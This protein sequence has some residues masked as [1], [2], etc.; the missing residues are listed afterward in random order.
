M[1]IR[2]MQLKVTGISPLL[3]NNPQTADPLNKYAKQKKTFTSKRDKTDNDYFNIQLIEMQSKIYW[4]EELGMYIPSTWIMG[5]LAGSSHK[6][7]RISKK[8][9]RGGVFTTDSKLKLNYK[10]SNKVKTPDDII[11][12][13]SF[14]QIMLL[15]QEGVRIPKAV[16]IF[17]DWSFETEIE[18]DDSVV[19][20]AN[21]ADI[22][23]HASVYGGYG[24]FRPTFGRGITE[25]IDD[26]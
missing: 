3:I 1:S 20:F 22:L 21:L 9:I 14:R 5:A 11:N 13:L 8:S 26:V 17:H 23:K 18:F 10:D 25:V 16:P 7:A 12:N 15:P 6:V 24:D 19:N 4:D 2:T